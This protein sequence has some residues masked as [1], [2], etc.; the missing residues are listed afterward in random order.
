MLAEEGKTHPQVD[1]VI[2]IYGELPGSLS[3]TLAA[4]SKQTYPISN[5]FVVDDGSPEPVRLPE[6]RQSSPRIALIRLPQNQGISAAR[7]EGIAHSSAPLLACINTEVVPDP[8]WLSTC[9]DLSFQ[10]SWRWRLL[11]TTHSAKPEAPAYPLANAV[12]GNQ[13]RR[14]IRACNLRPWPYRVISKRGGRGRGRLRPTLS[15]SP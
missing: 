6:E 10:P 4:C 12:S 3:A 13:I 7:N 5:I 11:Y 8:E 2:P 14:G 9:V 15:A 1:V